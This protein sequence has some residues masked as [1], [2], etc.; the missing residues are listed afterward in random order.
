MKSR[1]FFK[2]TN[3]STALAIACALLLT[4]AAVPLHAQ[5]SYTD[6]YEYSSCITTTGCGP[7]GLTQ[8]PD[9]NFYG[10]ASSGGA[11]GDGTVYKITPSGTYTDIY[12]FDG[13]TGKDPLNGLTLASDGNFYGTTSSGG[14]KGEGTVFR[15]TPSGTLTVLH[16][17]QKG[18]DGGVPFAPPVQ[19]RD[20]SLYGTT[21]A[22]TAYRITLP[23]GKYAQITAINPILDNAQTALLL[24]ADGYLYGTTFGATGVYS[25]GNVFRLSTSGNV[26]LVHA[27][28]GTDGANPGAPLVQGADGSLYGSTVF[29]G[30]NSTGVIF[31]LTLSGAITNLHTFTAQDPLTHANTDGAAPDGGL[32][33]TPDGMHFYGTTGV[34]GANSNGTI[35]EISSS[36]T[37]TKLFDFSGDAGSV[38]GADSAYAL[39]EHTNGSLYGATGGGGVNDEGV[40]YRLSPSGPIPILIIAGPVW[41]KPGQPVEILGDGLAAVS[42]I[43]FG[44]VA[45]QFQIGSDT[46]INATVPEAALDG[47]VVATLTTGKQIETQM[48]IHIQ[49]EITNLDPSSGT[50]GTVVGIVG[51]GFTGT[52]KVTFG[53]VKATFTVLN[54]TLIHATVPAGAKTGKVNVITPNGDAASTQTFTV[55]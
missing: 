12:S 37:F 8:G 43:T 6:L 50:P 42:S 13:T 32:L 40:F 25:D 55:N 14:A 9:G 33:P 34:G 20:K 27:F 15:I 18:K 39:V 22:G 38:P 19:A 7:R 4:F 46:N 35:F 1:T 45:A 51:G 31:K 47:P 23:A 48:A 41:V 53:G 30:A 52:T 44:G 5:F 29:G 26:K 17:F 11:H 24:G 16:Q 3:L 36:G 28:S 2:K 10:T 21:G 54:A 49:P